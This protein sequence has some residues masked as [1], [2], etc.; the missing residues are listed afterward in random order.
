M[1][2]AL[3]FGLVA[4]LA[5]P[6]GVLAEESNRSIDKLREQGYS[7]SSITPIFGQLLRMSYP[8]GFV[9][10]FEK[11]NGD[12]YIQEHVPPG[13]SVNAWT[14]MIT[15][16][17]KKD[18]A[19][20]PGATPV[21]VLNGMAGGFQRACPSSFAAKMLQENKLN[22]FDA[23]VAVVSCGASPTTQGKTSESALIV[24]VKGQTEIYTI[25]WAERAA[26]SDTPI[27]IELTKWQDRFKL[28]NP[29]KLCPI[30]PGERAPYPSCVGGE[31]PPT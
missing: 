9:G 6:A 5:L 3:V 26:R 7:V 17:G 29:I 8:K 25:Q 22:G 23:A 30:V 12:F 2:F 31:R 21:A 28:L 13:E 18:Y 14:Q 20:R 11:T 16:T 27:P 4:A 19:S 15:V 24:V 10:V 1:R